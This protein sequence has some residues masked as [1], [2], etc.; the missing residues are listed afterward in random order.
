MSHVEHYELSAAGPVKLDL[1]VV[2]DDTPAM[3][4]YQE[5]IKALPQAIA[6]SFD[7]TFDVRIAVTSNDGVAECVA[8]RDELVYGR[9]WPA[10]AGELLG[11]GGG[12]G[13]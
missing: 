1:L 8:N 9:W 4:L 7:P 6:Q 11:A 12:G 3:A 2:V 10:G 13:L 5:R